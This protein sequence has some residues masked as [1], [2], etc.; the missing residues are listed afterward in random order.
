M[1]LRSLGPDDQIAMDEVEVKDDVVEF[2]L[3]RRQ[4]AKDALVEPRQELKMASDQANVA[5]ERLE[6]PEGKTGRVGRFRIERVERAARHVE[7]DSEASTQMKI[8]LVDAD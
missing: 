8:T 7:F 6:L 5:L 3:E 1:A 4:K 2:A